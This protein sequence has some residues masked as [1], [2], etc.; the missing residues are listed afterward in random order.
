MSPVRAGN[1]PARLNDQESASELKLL[2]FL[3]F[4]EVIEGIGRRKLII[5]YTKKQI[6]QSIIL[7]DQKRAEK[8]NY[9]PTKTKMCDRKD[10][11][12]EEQ[13]AY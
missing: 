5:K 9:E 13:E 7:F 3:N 8:Q 6:I 10:R 2:F 4:I 12:E 11:F 1:L